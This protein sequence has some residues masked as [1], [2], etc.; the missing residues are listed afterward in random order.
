MNY[1]LRKIPAFSHLNS[2]SLA[3]PHGLD[4]RENLVAG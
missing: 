1:R 4:W 2:M 3:L